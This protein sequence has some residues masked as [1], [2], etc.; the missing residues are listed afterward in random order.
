VDINYVLSCELTQSMDITVTGY[1]GAT[2]LSLSGD[3]L[4]GDLYGVSEGSHRIVWDPTASAYTN[5]GI[6]TKFRV[7]LTPVISPLY[8]IVDLTKDADADGQI[9]YVYESDLTNGLWGAWV[10]NPVTNDGTVVES[11]VWTGVTTNDIY[12]TDK[13]VL[14]RVPAGSYGM[15]D[16]MNIAITLTKACYAGVFEVTVAQWTW[17]MGGSGTS[18]PIVGVSYDSIRGMTNDTPSVNWP[19]TGSGVSPA[20]FLGKLRSATGIA[21]FDLPTEAQWEYLCRAGTTTVF[22]DGSIDASF[23]GTVE[24]NNGNTNG[25]L[26]ALGWYKFN[27]TAKQSGGQKAANAW[28]IYDAHGNAGEWCL[29]WH[30]PSL[31]GGSD[32]S[33]PDSGSIRVYRGGAWSSTAD[34]CRSAYRNAIP[35]TFTKSYMG[36]R[37]VRTLP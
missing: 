34:R 36:F 17:V 29:D 16:S 12:A 8:M 26:S 19:T 13:L 32:P 20:S 9:E 11:V 14:R 25:Y 31:S 5:S 2:D 1:D 23:S 37:L 22:N 24:D 18:I 7:Q 3:A 4:S 35:S 21:D 33:G 30:E 6:L 15:G 28:G 27:C 10:R